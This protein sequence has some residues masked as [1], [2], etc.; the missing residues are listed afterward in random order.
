MKW[1]RIV[2]SIVAPIVALI[3]ALL[4]SSIALLLIHKNPF[5][6][7][8]AMVLYGK[9][10]N[11]LIA[12]VNAAVP[13]YLAALA[14][15]IGFK[16]NLFNIGVNGQYLLAALVAA[17]AGTKIDLP[18][19]IQIG[20]I[21]LVAI[22]VGAIWA[23]VAGVLKVA[24]GIHEVIG[25][26]MLNAIGTGL[27]SY[28]LLNHFQQPATAGNLST[29]T[30][31]LPDSAKFPSLAHGVPTD[32][33]GFVIIAALVGVLF[34][35]LVWR[36]RFGFDL[37]AAGAN[38]QAARVSGVNP[39]SMIVKTMLISGGIAGLVGMTQLLSFDHA[40]TLDFPADLGFAGI[41]VA[42]V[43][44]NHPVGIA[45]AALLFGF[46][47]ISSEILDFNDIP[48]EIYLIMEG[49]IILA[50]V[51]VYELVRRSVER[52]EVKAAAEQTRKM[53]EARAAEEP[54]GVPA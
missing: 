52:Q 38:F 39:G 35:V 29:Q 30:P 24:L 49:V 14:V 50:V 53:A 33:S 32:L 3:V 22:V 27:V 7:F 16:M 45:A 44:R 42:L 6:A 25:T 41:A 18:G 34:Y 13:L 54:E 51:I 47:Q 4:V 20:F 12:I 36:T 15:A 43:G 2:T 28:L 23:G 26:I 9:N 21:M 40:Y 8:K 10:P 19:P 1:R 11:Q 48:K 37:R 5:D 31:F 17:W 46:I